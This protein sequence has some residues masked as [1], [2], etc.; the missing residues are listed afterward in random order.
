M[1]TADS[2]AQREQST[3]DATIKL[4][5]GNSQSLLPSQAGGDLH[6]VDLRKLLKDSRKLVLYAAEVGI[7]LEDAV[8]QPILTALKKDK[9]TDAEEFAALKAVTTLATKV[10]PVTAETLAFCEHAADI[11]VRSYLRF[12]LPLLI[13]LILVSS[14]SFIAAS[15]S[16]SIGEDIAAANQLAIRL[17]ADN[18]KQLATMIEN[19]AADTVIS[20]LPTLTTLVT[21][22]ATIRRM[23]V[24]AEQLHP[25]VLDP[26]LPR[27]APGLLELR[28]PATIF[29]IKEKTEQLQDVRAYAERLRTRESV[30]N[31]MITNCILPS[32]YAVLGALVYL[33]KT[34]SEQIQARSYRPSKNRD[35]ARFTI[36]AIGG[37]VV[38][39]F[40]N[41]SLGTGTSLSVLAIAFLIGYA[42][43]VL[44]SVLDAFTKKANSPAVG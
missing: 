26:L 19:D 3:D 24:Q 21:F 6:D 29:Q 9:L 32:F 27:N 39:L 22:A 35:W 14:V 10:K 16:K 1:T 4:A 25:F 15:L 20:D 12:T 43:E 30:L 28:V 11:T 41:F 13:V 8:V 37:G 2:S 5:V 23:E 36:A 17:N 31:G 34:F 38:G 18:G 44:F 40:S 33:L 42:T 7:P